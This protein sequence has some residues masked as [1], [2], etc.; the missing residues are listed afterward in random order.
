MKIKYFKVDKKN[1]QIR[2]E[3]Y[4]LTIFR[5]IRLSAVAKERKV[6][7]HVKIMTCNTYTKYT[8]SY[9]FQMASMFEYNI[10]VEKFSITS[11]FLS[12]FYM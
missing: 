7:Y 1:N 2:L 9:C 3:N 8:P 4:Y 10:H 11:G 6:A 12:L 5:Q